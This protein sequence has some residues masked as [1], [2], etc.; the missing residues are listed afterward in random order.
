MTARDFLTRSVLLLPESTNSLLFACVLSRQSPFLNSCIGQENGELLD[1]MPEQFESDQHFSGQEKDAC[2]EETLEEIGSRFDFFELE[3]DFS[4]ANENSV[5]A[6]ITL[7]FFKYPYIIERDSYRIDFCLHG[8]ILALFMQDCGV[9]PNNVYFAS[10]KSFDEERTDHQESEK[11]Y[12]FSLNPSIKW[13]PKKLKV[14]QVNIYTMGKDSG[15]VWHIES[16]ASLEKM[17]C[18]KT[19]L[20]CFHIFGENPQV[21]VEFSVEDE[22]IKPLLIEDIGDV[23]PLKRALNLGQNPRFNLANEGLVKLTGAW[24][25][26]AI[27]RKILMAELIDEQEP[28]LYRRE[29]MPLSR[30]IP[31]NS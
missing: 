9:S 16:D 12:T 27:A 8:G 30:P 7:N 6:Y 23:G 24:R 2:L 13:I 18:R 26:K 25:K 10:L 1:A 29:N 11:V 19:E 28:Y 31:H 5:P 21:T 20:C 3:V 14:N 4:E 22:H 15:R 17:L